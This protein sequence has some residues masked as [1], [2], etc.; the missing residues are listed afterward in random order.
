MSEGY[1]GWPNYETWR[2]SLE[3]FDGDQEYW[4]EVLDDMTEDTAMEDVDLG[5]L[6]SEIREMIMDHTDECVDM[7]IEDKEG[8]ENIIKGWVRAFLG[9]VRWYK[10]AETI[11]EYWH[12]TRTYEQSR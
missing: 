3:M 1:N 7:V 5:E 9:D 12:E 8:L 2:V 6:T 11:V 4:N 10:I